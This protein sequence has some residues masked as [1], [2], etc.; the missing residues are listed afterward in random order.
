MTA[1]AC[2]YC[3]AQLPKMP[4]RKTRC[5]ACG[6]SMYVKYTPSNTTRRLMTGEQARRA[7]EEWTEKYIDD[8]QQAIAKMLELPSTLR[9][10]ELEEKVRML[11]GDEGEALRLR[12]MACI[13]MRANFS[14]TS[15]ERVAWEKRAI[16]LG[17]LDDKQKGIGKVKISGADD[18]CTT[19]PRLA[20]LVLPIDEAIGCGPLPPPQCEKLSR[21]GGC[22]LYYRAVLEG[23]CPIL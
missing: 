20:G 14:N 11:A 19:C 21:G 6:Q 5:K 8:K 12:A 22:N 18:G 7:E 16:V 9:G 15:H 2:P 23:W 17:L 10:A 3:C 13:S 4:A 1:P